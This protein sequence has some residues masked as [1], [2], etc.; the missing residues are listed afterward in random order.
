[1]TKI[2]AKDITLKNISNFTQG[3]INFANRKQL[4]DYVYEQY[5]YRA[6]VCRPCT[7]NGKCLHCGCHTP[8]VMFAPNKVDPISK[9]PTKLSEEDWE[10]YKEQSAYWAPLAMWIST[11]IKMEIIIDIRDDKLW[12]LLRENK[13]REFDIPSL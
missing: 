5:L 12:S 10:K 3:M 9:W 2:Q 4:P 7:I 11:L 8:H 6:F 13:L 1:M